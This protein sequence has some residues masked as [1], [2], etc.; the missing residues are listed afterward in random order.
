M[1]KRGDYIDHNKIYIMFK[2]RT[3]KKQM[4]KIS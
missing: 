3:F 1:K 2:K 4:N